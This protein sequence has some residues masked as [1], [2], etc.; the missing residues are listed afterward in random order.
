CSFLRKR[1]INNINY[2][3]SNINNLWLAVKPKWLAAIPAKRT[4]AIPS[5]MPDILIFPRKTPSEMT[6]L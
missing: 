4:N 6:T 1:K 5:D 3:N 2:L